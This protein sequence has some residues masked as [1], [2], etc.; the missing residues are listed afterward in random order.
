VPA[1]VARNPGT[2][3]PIVAPRARH[4]WCD[5]GPGVALSRSMTKTAF[6]AGCVFLSA[7]GQGSSAFADY[8]YEFATSAFSGATT[9]RYA[10]TNGDATQGEDVS[11]AYAPDGV[12]EVAHSPAT[13][14]LFLPGHGS[15]SASYTEFMSEAVKRGLLRHRPRLSERTEHSEPVRILGRLPELYARAERRKEYLSRLLFGGRAAPSGGAQFNQLPIE[16]FSLVF[17]EPRNRQ[18]VQLGAVL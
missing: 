18:R 5:D 14:L 13:L 3:A 12:H 8:H 15:S 7:L 1:R 2:G 16:R 9:E 10:R 17:E 11:F 4:L 6:V